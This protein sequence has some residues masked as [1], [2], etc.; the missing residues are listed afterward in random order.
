MLTNEAYEPTIQVCMLPFFFFYAPL[1]HA[2]SGE[3]DCG[4]TSSRHLH[5]L[6]SKLE[7][8]MGRLPLL[9]R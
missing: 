2:K 9:W 8:G 1:T 7:R 3:W 5:V 6:D 4:Q